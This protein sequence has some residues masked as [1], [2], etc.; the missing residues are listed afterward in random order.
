MIREQ[1]ILLILSMIFG[2]QPG[3]FRSASEEL[4]DAVTAIAGREIK[5]MSPHGLDA[6]FFSQQWQNREKAKLVLETWAKA[7]KPED[8]N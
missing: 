5:P 1:Q 6:D 3:D 4:K 7:E 2:A 8:K